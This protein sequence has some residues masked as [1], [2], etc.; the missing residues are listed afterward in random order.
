MFGCSRW[1]C[2]FCVF[3]RNQ[4]FSQEPA[5]TLKWR[6]DE[7]LSCYKELAHW[8]AQIRQIIIHSPRHTLCLTFHILCVLIWHRPS[9]LFGL[10][11]APEGKGGTGT[12]CQVLSGLSLVIFSVS[13]EHMTAEL[14]RVWLM[15]VF[16]QLS[17]FTRSHSWQ[18]SPDSLFHLFALWFASLSNFA[19]LMRHSASTFPL[20]LHLFLCHSLCLHALE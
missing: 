13:E 1:S 10:E 3:Q 11:S 8:K 5:E 12:M 4:T 9:D 18:E 2:C 15:A 16:P 17:A 19:S 20:T 7:L 14:R 6:T